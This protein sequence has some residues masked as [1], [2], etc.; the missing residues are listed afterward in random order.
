MLANE[1]TISIPMLSLFKMS[2]IE[3]SETSMQKFLA[4][5]SF[6]VIAS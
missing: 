5:V 3:L 1:A 4:A 2:E 6:A